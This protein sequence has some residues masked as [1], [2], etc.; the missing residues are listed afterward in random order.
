MP[1]QIN[2][3]ILEFLRA[4]GPHLDLAIAEALKV[5]LAKV[6]AHVADLASS[7]DLI[8]CNATQFV[9]GVAIEGIS[10]RPS[11]YTPPPARG[12]KPGVKKTAASRSRDVNA[13]D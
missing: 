9:N 8:C 4:K 13:H 5:P 10:C 3:S 1:N 12:R 7:G 11:C 2:A 6:R